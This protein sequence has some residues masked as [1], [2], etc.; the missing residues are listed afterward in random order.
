MNENSLIIFYFLQMVHGQIGQGTH[1]TIVKFQQTAQEPKI[2]PDPVI[3][4][5]LVVMVQR[6]LEIQLKQFLVIAI[7]VSKF[8]FQMSWYT[9][10]LSVFDISHKIWEEKCVST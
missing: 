1:A 2:R 4:Q 10:F 5:H 8:R 6:V 9:V 3:A 7:L